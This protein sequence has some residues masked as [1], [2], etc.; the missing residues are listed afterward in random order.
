MQTD[1]APIVESPLKTIIMFKRKIYSERLTFKT[2]QRAM[3]N[4]ETSP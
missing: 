1:Y 3:I 2:E 4:L